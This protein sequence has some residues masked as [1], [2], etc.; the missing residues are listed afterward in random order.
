MVCIFWNKMVQ[1]FMNAF[2]HHHYNT[3]SQKLHA[4]IALDHGK[5]VAVHSFSIASQAPTLHKQTIDRNQIDHQITCKNEHL[6]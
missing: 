6:P 3:R 2:A 5:S 4:G 1:V